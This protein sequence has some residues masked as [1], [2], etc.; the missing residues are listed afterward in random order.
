MIA[1]SAARGFAM[2]H[3]PIDTS[4]V[5][6]RRNRSSSDNWC[7]LR[8]SGGK[9]LRLTDWL[10]SAG[11]DAWTPRRTFKRPK[12]GKCEMIDG[13]KPMIEIDAPILP[14]FLFV[15]ARH[16]V[17]LAAIAS[18]PASQHPGFSIYTHAGRAP[19]IADSAVAGL[20]QAEAEATALIEQLRAAEDR[21]ERRRIRARAATTERERLK[22]LRSERRDFDIGEPVTIDGMAAFAGMIGV[23]ETSDGHSVLVQLGLFGRAFAVKVE[24]WQVVRHRVQGGRSVNEAAE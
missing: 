1:A 9:T 11:Y 21:E 17:E 24:A 13:R 7:L 3:Q 23:V 2:M 20:R 14:T 10:V 16:L 6:R 5:P 4:S 12:P 18:D 22:V 15:R 19:E 8:T